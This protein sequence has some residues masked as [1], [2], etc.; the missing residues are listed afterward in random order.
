MSNR[1]KLEEFVLQFRASKRPLM[2]M[3]VK[4][5]TEF[6]GLATATFFEEARELVRKGLHP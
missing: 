6:T 2:S 3:T 5:F 1:D 4:E